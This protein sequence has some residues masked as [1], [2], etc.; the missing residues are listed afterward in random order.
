MKTLVIYYSYS[1]KT[2]II[3]ENKAKKLGA[4]IFELKEI[5]KRGVFF[6]YVLGAHAAMKRKK[7]ELQ[8]ITVDFSICD[9]IIIA[10]P[11]WAGC[12][13][14]AFN[15]VVEL[16]PNGKEI[17]LIMTSGS[18]NSSGSADKTKAMVLAKDC[19]GVKYLDVK[20]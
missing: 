14:P 13:A 12:P 11:I 17:E 7:E 15:N 2:K 16:L 9:K 19:S 1:G 4:D 3:A 5:K 8:D 20:S 10:M 18:G 6:A